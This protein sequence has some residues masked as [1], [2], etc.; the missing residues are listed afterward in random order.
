[1]DLGP[2]SLVFLQRTRKFNSILDFSQIDILLLR[3]ANLRTLNFYFVCISDPEEDAIEK[4]K[5]L[6]AFCKGVT[7]ANNML[8][9]GELGA[10]LSEK[11]LQYWMKNINRSMSNYQVIIDFLKSFCPLKIKLKF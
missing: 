4:S 8:H 2:F 5:F 3:P 7:E 11:V 1:M 9:L 6:T 10:D